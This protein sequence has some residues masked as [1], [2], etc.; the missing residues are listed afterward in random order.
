M[1]LICSYKSSPKIGRVTIYGEKIIETE[2]KNPEIHISNLPPSIYILKIQN[3]AGL[4]LLK[5]LKE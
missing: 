2:L 3:K 4:S 1:N 5:F